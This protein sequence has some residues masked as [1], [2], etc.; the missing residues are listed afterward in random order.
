MMGGLSEN[1]PDW[2]EYFWRISINPAETSFDFTSSWSKP[3]HKGKVPYKLLGLNDKA[4]VTKITKFVLEYLKKYRAY[5]DGE[6]KDEIDAEE[7]VRRYLN[8]DFV[9]ELPE[10]VNQPDSDVSSCNQIRA[11]IYT[12]LPPENLV[13]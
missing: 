13:E 5:K 12:I 2:K 4:T 7:V 9:F 8:D 11:H 10:V 3:I 1:V 6:L